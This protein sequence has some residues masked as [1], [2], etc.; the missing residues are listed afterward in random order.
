MHIERYSQYERISGDSSNSVPLGLQRRSHQAPKPVGSGEEGARGGRGGSFG[1]A[2]GLLL[3]E[4][5]QRGLQQRGGLGL[6]RS[7]RRLGRVC[8][9][10]AVATKSL[11]KNK[12]NFDPRLR[13]G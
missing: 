5:A 1:S 10:R 7:K 11:L 3:G 2:L 8:A 12:I 6:G 13:S 4:I 9:P